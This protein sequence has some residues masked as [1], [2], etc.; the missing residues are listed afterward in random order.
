MFAA[1]CFT[2]HATDAGRRLLRDAPVHPLSLS[3]NVIHLNYRFAFSLFISLQSIS[4]TL[5]SFLLNNCSFTD[6]QFDAF[7]LETRRFPTTRAFCILSNTSKGSVLTLLDRSSTNYASATSSPRSWLVF[8]LNRSAM[9]S[10]TVP[11]GIT[12]FVSLPVFLAWLVDGLVTLKC[13]PL[14]VWCLSPE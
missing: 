9:K 8:R 11:L 7:E 10:L 13:Y 12:W 5:F 2:R 1:R 6:K 14:C 3:H 4:S